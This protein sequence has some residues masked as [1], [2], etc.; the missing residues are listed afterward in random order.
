MVSPF[1]PA[2]FALAF[3]IYG[4]AVYTAS[5]I[6]GLER[7]P[8]D[9]GIVWREWYIWK[10]FQ[11]PHEAWIRLK[12]GSMTER[13]IRTIQPEHWV[14]EGF[15]CPICLSTWISIPAALYLGYNFY[16]NPVE[17]FVVWLALRGFAVFIFKQERHG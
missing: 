2:S 1:S 14:Y 6:L 4:L 3:V 16:L 9:L 10:W 12:T 15:S 11:K 7:G 5:R 13:E 8:K 17:T